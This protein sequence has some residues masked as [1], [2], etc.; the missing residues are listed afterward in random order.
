[1]YF[2]SSTPARISEKCQNSRLVDTAAKIL[3][4]TV[5]SVHSCTYMT[6]IMSSLDTHVHA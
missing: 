3:M 2:S 6:I 1:M 5:S 4:E